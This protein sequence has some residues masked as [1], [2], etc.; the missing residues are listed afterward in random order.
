MVLEHD[1]E[2]SLA[3]VPVLICYFTG[4]C[5]CLR[6]VFDHEH[7]PVRVILCPVLVLPFIGQAAVIKGFRVHFQRDR[8]TETGINVSCVR[9]LFRA[10]RIR[11][12]LIID[13]EIESHSR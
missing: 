5:P 4:I 2:N 10:F 8:I 6:R 1:V 3:A 12:Q 7:I 9:A 11:I 13:M